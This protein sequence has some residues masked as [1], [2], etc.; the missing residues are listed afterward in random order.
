[1]GELYNLLTFLVHAGNTGPTNDTAR[2]ELMKL[3]ETDEWIWIQK[4]NWTLGDASMNRCVTSLH[5]IVF[6]C[7]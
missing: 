4:L 3:E 5:N 7:V 2:E 6:S 1:L